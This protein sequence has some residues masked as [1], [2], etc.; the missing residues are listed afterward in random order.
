MIM[1]LMPK[2]AVMRGR[3]NAH[4]HTLASSTIVGKAYL[5]GQTQAIQCLATRFLLFWLLQKDLVTQANFEGALN[6]VGLQC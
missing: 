3:S 5:P 2:L 6:S 4:G 1:R